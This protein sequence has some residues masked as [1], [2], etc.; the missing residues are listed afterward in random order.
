MLEGA[1]REGSVPEDGSG[2]AGYET[3][4]ADFGSYD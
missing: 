1:G 2:Y 3:T 4:V